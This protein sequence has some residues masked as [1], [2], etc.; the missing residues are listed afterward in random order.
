M[1]PK[2][3]NINISDGTHKF[4]YLLKVDPEKIPESGS[5]CIYVPDYKPERF[6]IYPRV[7][8]I[9]ADFTTLLYTNTSDTDIKSVNDTLRTALKTVG[10]EGGV[11]VNRGVFTFMF[12]IEKIIKP[13]IPFRHEGIWYRE[14]MDFDTLLLRMTKEDIVN[15]NL[16]PIEKLSIS[17]YHWDQDAHDN[18]DWLGYGSYFRTNTWSTK[19]I[20]ELSEAVAPLWYADREDLGVKVTADSNQVHIYGIVNGGIVNLKSTIEKMWG[21]NHNGEHGEVTSLTAEVALIDS[22]NIYWRREGVFE[23]IPASAIQ[24][25]QCNINLD[26]QFKLP[27][28]FIEGMK[29]MAI[30]KSIINTG[31]KIHHVDIKSSSLNV[32]KSLYERLITK[33]PVISLKEL[34]NMN[35]IKPRIVNQT[36]K[37]VIE[38]SS[39]TDSKSNI[40]QPVFF[41]SRDVARIVVHPAVSENIAIN[42][43]AYK[44]QVDRFYM[45]IE[46]IVFPE[47]GRI[48]SGVIFNIK[49]NQLPNE[50]QSGLYYI[51]SEQ[52]DLITSGKYIYEQ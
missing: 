7:V 35:L 27:S 17:F 1:L 23:T 33:S 40:I 18:I 42:L 2:F 13:C 52:G 34:K 22:D 41:R 24:A 37:Q 48:E 20:T 46:G 31:D 26:W 45:K 15:M 36:I 44:G 8:R 9:D 16:L 19:P 25:Q 49:G 3:S 39:Q 30:V 50:I 6:G 51:I 12:D 28:D 38:M 32:T 29:F 47:I 21:G 5:V 4:P 10:W 11:Y 14:Y 43:D